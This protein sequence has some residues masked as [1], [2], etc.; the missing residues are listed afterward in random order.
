MSWFCDFYFLLLEPKFIDLNIRGDF[1][2]I[3]GTRGWSCGFTPPLQGAQKGEGTCTSK[4]SETDREKC[5]QWGWTRV[6]TRGGAWSLAPSW[7]LAKL[8]KH[9]ASLMQVRECLEGLRNTC[10]HTDWCPPV[11]QNTLKTGV[12]PPV[13]LHFPPSLCPCA[14]VRRQEG[15]WVQC[16]TSPDSTGC[17]NDWNEVFWA[18]PGAPSMGKEWRCHRTVCGLSGRKENLSLSIFRGFAI[19]CACVLSHFSRVLLFVSLGL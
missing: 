8:Q 11:G 13:F 5:P 9:R 1:L 15:A 2:R 12:H 17:F 6:H 10:K 16:E 18:L 4:P 3:K 19:Q 14:H 7:M